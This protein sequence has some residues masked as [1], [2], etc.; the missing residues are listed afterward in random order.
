M[1]AAGSLNRTE[2][3]QRLDLDRLYSQTPSEPDSRAY[4]GHGTSSRPVTDAE[5][6]A[7]SRANGRHEDHRDGHLAARLRRREASALE[8]LYDSVAP[9]AYGLAYRVLGDGQSAE[10]V[11]QEAFAWIWD[12]SDRVD[13]NRGS[14]ESLLMTVVHRR[15]ID[16]VR[17]RTRRSTLGSVAIRERILVETVDVAIDAERAADADTVTRLVNNL[18]D[19]QRQILELAYFKGMTHVEIA[20]SLDIPLGTVKSRLRLAMASLRRSFR[21]GGSE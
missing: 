14:V 13:P 15:A 1:R 9:R 10:D 11:V 5:R 6:I 21:P 18:P 4:S 16:A 2:R 19:D 8:E 12:N 7:R 20:G 17:A 3:I